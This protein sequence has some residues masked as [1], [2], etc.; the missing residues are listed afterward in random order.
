MYS[1]SEKRNEST[2][3][4]IYNKETEARLFLMYVVVIF[5][6]LGVW[7][8]R[9]G[10]DVCICLSTLVLLTPCGLST[11]QDVLPADDSTS[12]WLFREKVT[13]LSPP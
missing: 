1:I 8:V 11:L 13:I 5:C 12:S 9:S 7:T 4:L 6:V 3:G 2:V 10:R